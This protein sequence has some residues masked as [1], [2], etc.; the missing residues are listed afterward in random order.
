M[1]GT[2]RLEK[3]LEV[4]TGLPR[5]ALEVALSGGNELLIGIA[6]IIVIITQV[7]AGSDRDLLGPFLQSPLV[8][9]GTPLR[10]LV[11]CLSGRPSTAAGGYFPIA[12]YENSPDH[13]LARGV[14]SGDVEGL[15]RGPGLIAAKLMHQGSTVRARPERRHDVGIADLGELMALLGE[16]LDVVP[17]GLS[18]LLP[19]SFRSQWLP[20]HMYAP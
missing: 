7:V 16:A 17:Q 5:L 3:L 6:D 9:L 15:L 14:S 2:C 13:L 1:I 4:I 11:S 8:A 18:M 12:L 20:S 19:Q 10:A